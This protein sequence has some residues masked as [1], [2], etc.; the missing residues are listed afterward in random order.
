MET[1]APEIEEA[2][3]MTTM[4][5]IPGYSHTQKAPLC[6][7][8][9]GTTLACMALGWI[10]SDTLGIYFAGGMGLLIAL[11]EGYALGSTL[12]WRNSGL[13]IRVSDV[14]ISQRACRVGDNPTRTGA[15]TCGEAVDPTG[16]IV[17]GLARPTTRRC[18]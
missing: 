6:L 1:T 2:K 7:I 12:F 9:Y 8:L 5:T 3:T 15:R 10:V 18:R 17:Q 16:G 4:T 14:V 13:F 11:L